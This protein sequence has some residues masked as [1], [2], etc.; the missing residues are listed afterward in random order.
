[1]GK[2]NIQINVKYATCVTAGLKIATKIA[3]SDAP[4]S[5]HSGLSID[6]LI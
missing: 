5:G 4:H 1:M 3:F 6:T 2:R